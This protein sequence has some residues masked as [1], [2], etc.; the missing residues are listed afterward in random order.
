MC[1]SGF[2]ACWNRDSGNVLP[3]RQLWEFGFGHAGGHWWRF[4]DVAVMLWKKKQICRSGFTPKTL[5]QPQILSC[6]NPLSWCR[7]VNVQ[8]WLAP[9]RECLHWTW[10][11]TVFLHSQLQCTDVTTNEEHRCTLSVEFFLHSCCNTM[12]TFKLRPLSAEFTR[13]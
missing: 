2:G 3:W 5:S 4:D 7:T 11:T 10:I 13:Q 1:C 8:G 9:E 6:E 12:F